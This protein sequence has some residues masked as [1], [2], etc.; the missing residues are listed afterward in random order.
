MKTE[1][2][3]RL[4]MDCGEPMVPRRNK[5]GDKFYGCSSFPDCHYTENDDGQDEYNPE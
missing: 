3:E 4:C 1:W 2:Q 5:D